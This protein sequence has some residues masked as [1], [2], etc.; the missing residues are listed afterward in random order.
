MLKEVYPNIYLN[1]IPL[2]NFPLKSVNSYI[3]LSGDQSIIIDTGFNTEEGREALR[4]GLEKLNIDLKKTKLLLTHMHPDHT[5]MASHLNEEGASV[6]IGEEDGAL[7]NQTYSQICKT[8]LEIHYE[9]LAQE[10]DIMPT[11]TAAFGN[12]ATDNIEFILLKE[13]DRIEIGDYSFEVVEI[14][15][16][17]P[18]HIGLY[19]RKHKLF[20]CGDHILERITPSILFW[21]YEV[22]IMGSYIKSLKKIFEMEID[23]LFCA[24]FSIVRDHRARILQLLFQCEERLEEV[25]SVMKKGERTPREVAARLTWNVKETWEN[26]SKMQKF[27]AFG[28]TMAFLEHLVHQGIAD[29]FDENGNVYYKLKTGS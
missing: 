4:Q 7:I 20:F 25:Q 14:P 16:H 3:I 12:N 18:G 8:S 15:G 24:H 29:R 13:N 21:G 23:Y 26:F 6:Y 9:E 28:E 11:R 2:P 22:D 17:T 27:L 10:K 1:E 19:D 5:G